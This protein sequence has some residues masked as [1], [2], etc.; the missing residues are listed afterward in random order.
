MDLTYNS[1]ET[2]QGSLISDLG[3]HTYSS[4]LLQTQDLHVLQV[5]DRIC[6]PRTNN[7]TV[8]QTK[9][10]TLTKWASF[11]LQRLQFMLRLQ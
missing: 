7:P 3:M 4:N 2:C 1:R 10:Y 9:L 5:L 6:C 8:P 11:R